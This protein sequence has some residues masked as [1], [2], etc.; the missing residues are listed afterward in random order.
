VRTG[1]DWLE[2]HLRGQLD[3]H[4]RLGIAFDLDERAVAYLLGLEL[5]RAPR[6]DREGSPA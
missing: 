5:Q 2:Y 1:F 3:E 6:I 4:E